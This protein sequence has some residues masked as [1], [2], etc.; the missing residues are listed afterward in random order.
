MIGLTMA[1]AT[2]LFVF[3]G[4]KRIEIFSAVAA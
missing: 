3:T 4:A 2:I 1:F